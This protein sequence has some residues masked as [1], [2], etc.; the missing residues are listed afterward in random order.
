MIRCLC[1]VFLAC[2]GPVAAGALG[3]LSGAAYLCGEEPVRA[4]FAEGGAVVALRGER[5]VLG[6]VRA[7]SGGRYEAPGVVFWVKGR[8]AMLRLGAEELDCVEDGAAGAPYRGGGNEPGWIVVLEDGQLRLLADYG[9]VEVEEPLTGARIEGG[10]IFHEGAR[11]AVRVTPG[12]CRDDA[13][14]MPHPDAVEVR[15]DDRALDGCGG[16]P[17]ALLEGPAWDLVEIGGVPAAEGAEILFA[18]GRLS[19]SSGCNRFTGAFEVSGERVVVGPLAG[20]R[21]ACPAPFGEQE[22]R[23][24]EALA[25]VGQFD[26]DAEGQLMLIDYETGDVVVRAAR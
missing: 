4:G 2:A 10:V 22:Q 24:Y 3:G 23:H 12:L 9:E 1:L 26:F 11:V 20:T 8:A 25:G 14:G 6:Q 17:E 19:G 5:F 7:A 18:E 16:A 13:T 21:M 15:W